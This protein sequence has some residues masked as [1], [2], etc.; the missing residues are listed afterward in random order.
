MMSDRHFLETLS[1]FISFYQFLEVFQ[2]FRFNDFRSV[3]VGRD[4][5]C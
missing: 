3:I 2:F 5:L 4:R 1:C